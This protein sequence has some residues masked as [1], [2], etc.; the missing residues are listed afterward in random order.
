M[1]GYPHQEAIYHLLGVFLKHR[2]PEPLTGDLHQQDADS[3]DGTTEGRWEGTSMA[4]GC[5]KVLNG[6]VDG[7]GLPSEVCL[8]GKGHKPT[9]NQV[10]FHTF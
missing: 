5:V 9:G 7:L 10:S 2:K 1:W 8:S 6:Q 4:R 3:P